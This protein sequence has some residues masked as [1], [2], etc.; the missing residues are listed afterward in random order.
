VATTGTCL[1]CYGTDL[2][3][4]FPQL[5]PTW[6]YAVGGRTAITQ[7]LYQVWDGGGGQI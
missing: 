4:V 7:G 2:Y 5:S 3:V 6:Q 1:Y